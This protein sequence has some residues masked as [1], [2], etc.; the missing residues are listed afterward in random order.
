MSSREILHFCHLSLYK[1]SICIVG[2]LW[3]F[4]P[5]QLKAHN[6]FRWR[7][8][9]CKT[10]SEICFCFHWTLKKW[11]ICCSFSLQPAMKETLPYVCTLLSAF[12]AFK[13]HSVLSWSH[14]HYN[15]CNSYQN[16][17]ENMWKEINSYLVKKKKTGVSWL[18]IEDMN[19]VW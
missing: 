11:R 13:R 7:L 12:Q 5:E 6:A 10:I 18:K 17:C 15:Q 9:T 1:V 8:L 2:W 16:S 3:Y 14:V 4:A 19:M